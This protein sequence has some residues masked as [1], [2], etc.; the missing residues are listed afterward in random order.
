MKNDF[1]WGVMNKN[2]G[3]TLIELL[4]VI[5]IISIVAA[6]AVLSIRTNQTK[7]LESMSQQL[8][9]LFLLAEEEA[10][11]RSTTLGFAF[12]E[13]S[14]RFYEYHPNKG[15][16]AW[17]PLNHSSLGLH[18]IPSDVYLVLQING[19]T[20]KSTE[21][22]VIISQSG[23]ITPFTLL[24]GKRDSIPQFSVIGSRSGNIKSQRLKSE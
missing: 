3:F 10:M 1:V 19:K 7:R 16:S 15:K 23:D 12:T 2:R 18:P 21:P 24:I 14:F 20:I 6:F 13:D 5:L 4:V 22:K 9:N 17:L 11:L 8:V